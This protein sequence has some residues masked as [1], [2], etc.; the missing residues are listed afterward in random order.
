MDG[1][2]EY[3]EGNVG[4]SASSFPGAAPAA[5]DYGGPSTSTTTMTA[6]AG[7][8]A[9]QFVVLPNNHQLDST[10]ESFTTTSTF[11]GTIPHIPVHPVFG[12]LPLSAHPD[13]DPRIPDVWS[14]SE[15]ELYADWLPRRAAPGSN[16]MIAGG[17]S[18]RARPDR[19]RGGQ[20]GR[21]ATLP[22]R[23]PRADEETPNV[24]ELHPPRRPGGMLSSS[25]AATGPAGPR[26]AAPDRTSG[27]HD[28]TTRSVAGVGGEELRAQARWRTELGLDEWGDDL[29][30][31]ELEALPFVPFE[32][33]FFSGSRS[34]NNFAVHRAGKLLSGTTTGNDH[35]TEEDTNFRQEDQGSEDGGCSAA[36]GPSYYVKLRVQLVRQNKTCPAG[37][38]GVAK[39]GPPR[40]RG[41]AAALP[42]PEIWTVEKVFVVDANAPREKILHDVDSAS[43]HWDT[44]TDIKRKRSLLRKNGLSAALDEQQRS[45]PSQMIVQYQTLPALSPLAVAVRAGS[46][47]LPKMLQ[48]LS[49][50]QGEGQL[51]SALLSSFAE[52]STIAQSVFLGLG[53][54]SNEM[55]DDSAELDR[56]EFGPAARPSRGGPPATTNAPPSAT[57]ESHDDTLN[58][59]SPVYAVTK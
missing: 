32:Q 44:I 4:M 37:A 48:L 20:Q 28:S 19:L 56:R 58:L 12:A 1:D 36:R 7:R 9:E 21:V 29:L 42:P 15:R 40:A 39:A 27:V 49:V 34:I 8:G 24:P 59:N 54:D 35:R 22:G 50:L 53:P 45:S 6:A 33:R 23:R 26:G 18:S 43:R 41:K 2:F 13:E 55:V 3:Y 47:A 25:G 16:L 14:R 30:E 52:S 31:S 46:V 17:S 11:R 10:V 51:F 5:P 38:G 57:A